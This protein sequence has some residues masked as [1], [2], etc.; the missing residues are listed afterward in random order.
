MKLQGVCSWALH[1]FGAVCDE[2]GIWLTDEQAK[3]LVQYRGCTFW[4]RKFK[5]NSG[6]QKLCNTLGP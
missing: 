5:E 3:L 1:T 6:W 2:A 4:G